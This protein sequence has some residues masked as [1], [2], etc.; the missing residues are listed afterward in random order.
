MA[1]CEL[2]NQYRVIGMDDIASAQV[3]EERYPRNRRQM[4][5]EWRALGTLPCNSLGEAC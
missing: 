1:W 5:K 2:D 4:V 3:L